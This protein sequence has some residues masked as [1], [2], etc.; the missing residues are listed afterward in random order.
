MLA[1]V[2][3]RGL[4]SAC[5]ALASAALIAACGG[6]SPETNNA[7]SN[8]VA[9]KPAAAIVS[10]AYSAVAQSKSAH[11]SGVVRSE[12]QTITLDIDVLTGRGGKG[13][14]SINGLS[15]ELISLGSRF[16]FKASSAFWQHYGG[17]GAAALFK[18]KWLQ[19]SASTSEFKSFAQLT[20]PHDLFQSLLHTGGDELVK[21][22]ISTVDGQ[23]VIGVHD[24]TQGGTLYVATVG[25]PY[26][27]EIE[28]SGSSGGRISINDFDETVSIAAPAGAIS[29]SELKGQ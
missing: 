24:Q 5:L 12:K 2:R 7:A 28:K 1:Q 4:C 17:A 26:P 9:S 8:G 16:Y 25:K 21:T 14:M 23:R 29:L 11:I 27:I 3:I 18:G 20:N 19:A 22:G 6:S 15:F 13:S 10:A